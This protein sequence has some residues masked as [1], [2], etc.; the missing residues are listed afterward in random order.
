MQTTCRRAGDLICPKQLVKEV[1]EIVVKI[2][3]DPS[4][5]GRTWVL[6]TEGAEGRSGIAGTAFS[7]EEFAALAAKAKASW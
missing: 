1:T 3:S 4:Q 6:L 7:R 2:S 5:A